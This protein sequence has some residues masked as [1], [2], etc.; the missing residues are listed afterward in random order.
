ML[1]PACHAQ[2]PPGAVFCNQ[3]GTRLSSVERLPSLIATADL[4]RLR[5]YLQPGQFDALPPAAA[6]RES[7]VAT[8]A[9]QLDR[10][11][12]TV[13]TYL[14]RHLVQTEL[15]RLSDPPAP[16]GGEFLRGAL[17]FADI[18]G[19]TAIS[20][21]LS[22]LGREGAEQV[23]E[24]VNRYY[25]AMLQIVFDHGGD[26]YKFGGDA[27]LVLFQDG[28]LPGAVPAL[29]AGWEMQQAMSA[30]AEVKTSIGSFPLRVKI[31][32]NAGSFFA[33]RLGRA[34][35]RQF[36]V[37]GSAANATATA[38]ALAV[39]G[40]ILVTPTVQAALD[41]PRW[42]FHFMPGPDDHYLL[43]SLSSVEHLLI[44]PSSID[45]FA[46]QPL[47]RSLS[48]DSLL[49]ALDRL[50]PYLP[51][52]LLP[53][54]V[55]DPSSSQASGGHRLVGVLLANFVGASE[56]I[57]RLGSGR[58]DEIARDLNRYFVAMQAAV[59]RYGGAIN[60]VDLY[61]VGDKLMALFGAPVA[62]EDDA[63]RT[64]RAALD[65]QTAEAEA[66]SMLISQRI[67]VNF[68][69]VFAG[70]V[71]STERREYTV[72]GDDVNLS[73]RLMSTADEGELLLSSAIRRKVSPF[74][75]LADRGA[76]KVKGKAQ[77]VPVYSVVGRR[78]QPE[79]IRGI[80]GLY[81]PVGGRVAETQ[82]MR[83]LASGLRAGRGG[84]LVL[85][86]EAGVGKSRLI[87][88]LQNEL[89]EAKEFTWLE[90]HCLSSTQNVSYSAFTDM[91][92]G[93]LGIF[94][95]DS[96]TEA[97]A[98]L[99]KHIDA[100][101]PGEAGEDVLPYLAHFLNLPLS[102]SMAERVAYLEGEALQRQVIRAVAGLL[103]QMA[104]QRPLVMIFDDLHW[105]DSASLALL[106]RCLAMPD[107]APALIGMLYRPERS[108]DSWALGQ[109]LRAT[110]L[111]AIPR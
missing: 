50:V 2:N 110:I 85:V 106:E 82:S 107:R 18:S 63:E 20:E 52:G 27:L 10:L 87:A 108:H 36:I 94:E 25:R 67:G 9:G 39:A 80:R 103:E 75:E 72:M 13:I 3:C 65:M 62:H 96:E 26:L 1:C 64:V 58:E 19:F 98:K 34:D 28:E 66:G 81:S 54:L 56:L 17:M 61:Q 74:F 55:S 100:L 14:P 105:A 76:V 21:R 32:L 73:A 44:R 90:S 53:R 30:F 91:V 29:L 71:G 22:V 86:G 31:G 23:T 104:R 77:P 59:D 95:N 40:Q 12:D 4:A 38:Q 99:R 8:T 60:K 92:R 16:Y 5:A 88:E 33:A 7:D 43:D 83:A 97:W 48:V 70:H 6:W 57:E 68:G 89:G 47:I 69:V 11:L 111:I 79:P 41:E 24:I 109:T 45:Q 51:T 42:P 102:D 78:S 35:D 84:I 49:T 46:D 15:D 37:T 93:A 101:L